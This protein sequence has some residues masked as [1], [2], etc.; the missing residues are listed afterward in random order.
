MEKVEEGLIHSSL[1]VKI[2][3][4]EKPQDRVFL[5]SSKAIY[6]LV[7]ITLKLRRRIPLRLL[8]GI[9]YT[10]NSSEFVIHVPSEYDYRYSW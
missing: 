2:N 4:H 6:N 8:D 7:P 10:N 5:L 9:T 3:E 1:M